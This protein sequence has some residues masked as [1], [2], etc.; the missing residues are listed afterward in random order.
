M[1]AEAEH[2]EGRSLIGLSNFA[3][4]PLVRNSANDSAHVGGVLNGD[5]G[6]WR[7]SATGNGDIS[8]SVTRTDRNNQTSRDRTRIAHHLG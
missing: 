8:R 6:K 3:F 5:K 1:N 2:N 7:W 4:E